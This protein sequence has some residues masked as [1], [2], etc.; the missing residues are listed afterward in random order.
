VSAD[1]VE[2]RLR[3]R[4]ELGS[5][6]VLD[7]VCMPHCRC[8]G[9]VRAAAAIVRTQEAVAWD[10]GEVPMRLFLAVVTPEGAP[11]EHLRVLAELSRR[12]R[13]PERLA[14]LLTAPTAE[15]M[16]Q[17]WRRPLGAAA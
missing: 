16:L 2:R 3:E 17:V 6:K 10:D 7:D 1:E 8:R 15:A 4:E 9:I 5:T 13:E 14:A 11:A 12:I